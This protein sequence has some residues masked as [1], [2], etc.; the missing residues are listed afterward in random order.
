M[1]TAQRTQLANAQTHLLTLLN[2][3]LSNQIKTQRSEYGT[4]RGLVDTLALVTHVE[5]VEE[6]NEKVQADLD[7]V[8]PTLKPTDLSALTITSLR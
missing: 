2:T 8:T 4:I 3:E 7:A 5:Q 1:N 6:K